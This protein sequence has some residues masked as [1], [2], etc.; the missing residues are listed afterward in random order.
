[1]PGTFFCRGA[2]LDALLRYGLSLN[3]SADEFINFRY[4]GG[5]ANGE[6]ANP[7]YRGDGYTDNWLGTLSLSVGL[8]IK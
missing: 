1:M 7:E 5:G 8:Y 2:T 4:I 6:Q 3:Q